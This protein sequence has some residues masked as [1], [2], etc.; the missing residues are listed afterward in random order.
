M[1]RLYRFLPLLLLSSTG[2]MQAQLLAPALTPAPKIATPSAPHSG[3]Q[4]LVA[5]E[6]TLP[7]G[8]PPVQSIAAYTPLNLSNGAVWTGLHGF[9]DYQANGEA[10]NYV[11][12]DPN[13]P[14]KISVVYM[15]SLDDVDVTTSAPSRRVGYAYSNDGGATWTSTQD[16]SG[17]R[18][19]YPTI[20]LKSD[21]TA[22]I[23]A[24]GLN[25]GGFRT[26][27]FQQDSPG[28][29]T[30]Y[31]LADL[32]VQ[33]AS[34]RNDNATANGVIWPA[35]ALTGNESK[36]IV[37]GGYSPPTGSTVLSPLQVATVD[38]STG[39][40]QN[41]TWREVA[42]SLISSTSGGH[43][44]IARSAS[45]KIGV[46]W[47][48]F[49][50]QRFS[51]ELPAG[52]FFTESN[53]DGATWSQPTVI[54]DSLLVP[55]GAN[56]FS[57]D[58]DTLYAEPEFDLVYADE[59]PH[60]AFKASFGFWSDGDGTST[61]PAG[62]PTYFAGERILHWRG[63]SNT[64]HQ[65]G[66][67]SAT[68]GI[69]NNRNFG[70]KVQQ[71]LSGINNPS[72]SMGSD[73]QTV[74]ISFNTVTGTIDST[75]PNAPTYNVDTTEEG[76]AYY[77][78]VI[79]GSRD[80][81]DNWGDMHLIQPSSKS[82]ETSSILYPTLADRSAIQPNGDAQMTLGFQAKPQPGMY[83]VV[84]QDANGN[85]TADRG[86]GDEA[87]FYVQRMMLDGSY[88]P[89]PSSVSRSEDAAG[90]VSIS[91]TWPNPTASNAS[92]EYT[93][94]N[95]NPAV[96]TLVDAMGREVRRVEDSRPI[97][98]RHTQSFNVSDLAAGEYRVVVSQSGR[99][100]SA[101]LSIVR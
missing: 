73:N 85:P 3:N 100:T 59:V 87:G 38:I 30:F 96:V 81:G 40:V 58:D 27:M 84:P 1:K 90:T 56:G 77:S 74:L 15:L 50:S 49:L 18:L 66:T 72:I 31:P 6:H 80:G 82:G 39:G 35:F 26:V 33:T 75:D 46:V 34:G 48:T 22:I 64:L 76:F 55:T 98:G 92:V 9:Y 29:T 28:S 91:R 12:V 67:F 94:T 71:N 78:A 57:G 2:I 63:N 53:D 8:Q 52:I 51:S 95:S 23:A 60:V 36:A 89:A 37:L 4:W 69:G 86:P 24:H 25:N 61:N 32:P 79:V 68:Q 17:F 65:V 42:D 47:G 88:F 44:A 5:P 16:I 14:N 21:G 99:T 11:V 7:N 43:Y 41:D 20:Q 97:A 45:G 101:P 93:L 70:T 10:P 54:L 62:R 19:G 13:D 83:A